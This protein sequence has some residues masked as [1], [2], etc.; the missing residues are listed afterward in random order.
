MAFTLDRSETVLTPV[1][2]ADMAWKIG[3]SGFEMVLSSYVPHIIDEHI[4]N[5]LV[6]LFAPEPVLATALAAGAAGEA[7]QHWAIHPGGRSILDKVEQKLG[8]SEA[9][10][11]PARETLRNYGNM[12][13]ATVLFVLKHILEA[14]DTSCGRTRVGDGLRAGA[15]RRDRAAQRCRCA[16][17]RA[18][19][20]RG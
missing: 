2:E 15:H 16:G 5:A 13:S 6:P 3:D 1:G 9:Q 20:R 18:C 17:G 14:P 12:S 4:G 7:V 8:L 19:G 11:V 10:L